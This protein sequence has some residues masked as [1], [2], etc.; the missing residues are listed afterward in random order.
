[1][2]LS[3]LLSVSRPSYSPEGLSIPSLWTLF[4]WGD[5]RLLE[6]QSLPPC[7]SGPYHVVFLPP[8]FSFPLLQRRSF[9]VADRGGNCVL[10]GKFW[11]SPRTIFFRSFFLSPPPFFFPTI[12]SSPPCWLLGRPKALCFLV[13]SCVESI[14]FHLNFLLERYTSLY[15]FLPPWSST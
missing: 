14:G 2:F 10:S 15:F 1:L 6:T 9:V 11:L 13:C 12:I 8:S 4:C 7:S 5:V 3:P